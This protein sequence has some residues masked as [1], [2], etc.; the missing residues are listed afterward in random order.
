MGI[1][2]RVY[3]FIFLFYQRI[4]W[5]A[6]HAECRVSSLPWNNLY[7]GSLTEC[8]TVTSKEYKR[9][10]N[11]NIQKANRSHIIPSDHTSEVY[12][13]VS[14]P[15]AK[16]YMF[17]LPP[18]PIT[19][20]PHIIPIYILLISTYYL[21]PKSQTKK[22]EPPPNPNQYP[23]SNLQTPN[24]ITTSI[25][26]TFLLKKEETKISASKEVTTSRN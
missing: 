22:E 15:P 25:H 8:K 19:P 23:N 17:L 20:K 5:N 4:D 24:P 9:N 11:Q 16:V 12:G 6:S 10:L 2:I 13:V 26:P 21:L 3:L 18:H 7:Q 1:I 14:K